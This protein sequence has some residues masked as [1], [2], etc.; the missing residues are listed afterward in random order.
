MGR[1]RLLLL[2]VKG[3]SP[4]RDGRHVWAF[5]T[6]N[7]RGRKNNNLLSFLGR[8]SSVWKPLNSSFNNNSEIGNHE[9]F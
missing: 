5:L 2:I 3:P 9:K 6:V 4:L 7:Q 1:K 8:P